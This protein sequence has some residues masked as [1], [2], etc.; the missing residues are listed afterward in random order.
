MP[1]LITVLLTAVA[2]MGTAS[3][4]PEVNFGWSQHVRAI[5]VEGI[6]RRTPSHPNIKEPIRFARHA[7]KPAPAPAA[8]LMLS[9]ELIPREASMGEKISV[10][11]EKRESTR[12]AKKRQDEGTVEKR[13]ALE[14]DGGVAEGVVV[15]VDEEYEDEIVEGDS[16]NDTQTWNRM[17][18][19]EGKEYALI[20]TA[21]TSEATVAL[22]S[23][24]AAGST[25]P[26]KGAPPLPAITA[27]N[28]ANYPAL[29]RQPP[30]DSPEVQQ[31]IKEVNLANV[32]NIPITGLN[33]CSNATN[34]D[35]LK[36]AGAS[37]NCWWTCGGCTRSTDVTFCPDK[38]TWG[39][40]YDDGPSPYTP[41]LLTLLSSQNLKSTFFIVGSRAI[42][43]PEMV[44]TEYME[45]HQLS[46]HT[47][48]H[49]ALTTMSNEE[50][51]AELGWTKKIIKDITG[52]TPNTMRPPYGDIDDRVRYISLQ[53]GLTP[54]I[55]TSTP[56]G[57]TF[58]TRDWQIGGGVVNA[59]TVYNNFQN[60]IGSATTSLSTGFIVLA[61]DLQSVDLAVNYI[62]PSAINAKTLSLK[63][64]VTCL[65]QD[66]AQA[67]IETAT[68]D[69][70]AVQTT[71]TVV[72][73]SGVGFVSN[74]GS[75]VASGTGTSPAST[76]T[77]TAGAER[78]FSRGGAWLVGA[79]VAGVVGA[80]LW[81]A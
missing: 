14:R 59:T 8:P 49:P 44:Q 34:A 12:R 43:R 46:V 69:T 51:I 57:Q 74:V 3:A 32:P 56:Q 23:T 60:I 61:H 63:P 31:W 71:S 9:D 65:G 20:G 42:S 53:M 77:T 64:I 6:T 55:W 30:I 19:T 80:G 15:V 67:Y 29:D 27:L 45:G 26:V 48:A 11:I 72:G 17:L 10:A 36:N 1:S 4:A 16:L 33:G 24:Y 40:S 73:A 41:E 22:P 76:S 35:A 58:D 78:L 81:M 38:N 21:T 62:L 18:P 13:G 25:P 79:T 2:F 52:V 37:G 54:I 5:K 66:L 70:E 50:I 68:N 47:W 7:R 39:L 75:T 28:P